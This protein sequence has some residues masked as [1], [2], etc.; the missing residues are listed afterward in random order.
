M[1]TLKTFTKD[2]GARLDYTLD[3]GTDGWLGSD[4]I[5]SVSWTVPSGLTT[6]LN[7]NTTTTATIWLASGTV[8]TDYTVTCQITTAAGRVDERSL[9]IQVRQR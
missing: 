2:P 8:N 4:T 5:A 1:A 3:W 9:L 7:T 6:N